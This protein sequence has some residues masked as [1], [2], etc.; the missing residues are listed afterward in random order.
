MKCNVDIVILANPRSGSCYAAKFVSGE[1]DHIKL[2]SIEDTIIAC[3][4]TIYDITNKE[5]KPQYLSK[6][7]GLA[8]QGNFEFANLSSE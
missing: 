1:R 5:E 4:L 2:L 3:K 6:I 7:E 8:P